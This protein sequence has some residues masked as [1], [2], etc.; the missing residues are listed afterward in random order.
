[1]TPEGHLW[2]AA[3]KAHQLAHTLS[4]AALRS[5]SH[6]SVSVL[7]VP[8]GFINAPLRCFGRSGTLQW[9]P[10]E[11]RSPGSADPVYLRL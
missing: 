3:N 7:P 11:N 10:K 5:H 2:T 8:V 6:R 4:H 1:M 9:D